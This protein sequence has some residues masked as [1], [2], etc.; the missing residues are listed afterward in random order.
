MAYTSAWSVWRFGGSV[1]VVS[2]IQLKT[3]IQTAQ[4]V[5]PSPLYTY[6]CPCRVAVLHVRFFYSVHVIQ[7]LFELR[8]RGDQVPAGGFGGVAGFGCRWSDSKLPLSHLLFLPSRE[9]IGRPRSCWL[10]DRGLRGG[11]VV[12]LSGMW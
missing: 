9:G 3:E 7:L 2:A 4:H 11:N 1:V 10:L 6:T 12:H 8:A 5:T